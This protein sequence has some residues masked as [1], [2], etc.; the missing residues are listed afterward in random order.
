MVYMA[1]RADDRE[2]LL[3]PDGYQNTVETIAAILHVLDQKRIRTCRVAAAFIP[4]QAR[5]DYSRND[6]THHRAAA[7]R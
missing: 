4:E 6:M 1:R 3:L 7:T 2:V 5:R